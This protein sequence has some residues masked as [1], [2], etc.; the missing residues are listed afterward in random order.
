VALGAEAHRVRW[1]RLSRSEPRKHFADPT[2][3]QCAATVLREVLC[4]RMMRSPQ[5]KPIWRRPS[6]P[7]RGSPRQARVCLKAILAAHP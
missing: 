5:A 1:K 2:A 4:P 3:G 6:Q 7:L